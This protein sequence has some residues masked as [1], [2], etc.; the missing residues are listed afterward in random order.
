LCSKDTRVLRAKAIKSLSDHA[1]T[2]VEFLKILRMGENDINF[3]YH[4]S[5][6][7]Q[8]DIQTANDSSLKVVV[9][10]TKVN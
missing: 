2:T 5:L 4:A 7:L 8:V 10:N 1:D 9:D 6:I 3:D